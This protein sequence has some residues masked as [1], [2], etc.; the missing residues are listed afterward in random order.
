MEIFEN[1]NLKNR[2]LFKAKK[3][4]IDWSRRT[5]INCYTKIFEYR[6]NLIAQIFWTLILFLLNFF[7]F[8]LISSSVFSY[9]IYDVVTKISVV[10]EM[11]SKFPTITFCNNDAFT[12]HDSQAILEHVA[13]NNSLDLNSFADM[14]TITH[15]AK[16]HAMNPSFGNENRKRLG[17]SLEQ[18]FTC[19]YGAKDCSR[20]ELNWFY[21]FDYGNCYQFNSGFLGNEFKI[22]EM[23]GHRYGLQITIGPLVNTNRYV[24]SWNDG[25]VIFV[26]NSSSFKPTSADGVCLEPGK[27]TFISVKKTITHKHPYPYSKCIELDDNTFKSELYDFILKSNKAYRQR[28]CIELCIQRNI[29][30]KCNCYSLEIGDLNTVKRPCLNLTDLVCLLEQ[31]STFN[32]KECE[33]HF[34][35]L[36]CDSIK[37]DLHLLTIV[38]PNRKG[39]N[40]MNET[41]KKFMEK[42]LNQSLTYDLFKQMYL[43]FNV[44]YSYL[45]YSEMS[46]TPKVSCVDLLTQIG[47]SLG[48]FFSLS[49]F[50]LFEIFEVIFLVLHASFKKT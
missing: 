6:N 39:F 14:F 48:M 4:F 10:P 15:L 19:T 47:G 25:I 8:W 34:C 50:T 20:H 26:H 31:K 24:S 35:P 30:K 32:G 13:T 45:E 12:T 27:S 36:E 22:V 16:M 38:F 17:L 2:K 11:S 5:D 40:S 46:E 43:Q 28:D 9:L 7:T 29:I 1:A 33:K 18:M 49:V 21:S 23:Q 42:V 37:Y 44:F 41:S 3:A